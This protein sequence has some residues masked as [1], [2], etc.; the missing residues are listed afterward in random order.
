MD[1]VGRDLPAN[2]FKR[3]NSAGSHF[4]CLVPLRS[5]QRN[6]FRAEPP[7]DRAQVHGIRAIHATA[8]ARPAKTLRET[9]PPPL[10]CDMHPA[11]LPASRGLPTQ[12]SRIAPVR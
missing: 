2:L 5:F 9:P 3:R 6:R 1:F 12:P 4:S 7:A 10:Q 11:T 8:A